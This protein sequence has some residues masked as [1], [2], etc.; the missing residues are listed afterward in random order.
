[1]DRSADIEA[2][3]ATSGSEKV[4]ARHT[5]SCRRKCEPAFFRTSWHNLLTDAYGLYRIEWLM[6]QQ[7]LR[8]ATVL[9]AAG[10]NERPRTPW[11]PM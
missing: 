9:L 10:R 3:G 6:C 11:L 2:T 8:T 7:V 5:K 4:R 1:M